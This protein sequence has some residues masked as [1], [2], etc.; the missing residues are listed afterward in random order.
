MRSSKWRSDVCSSDLWTKDRFYVH[1][2]VVKTQSKGGPAF[3]FFAQAK[4]RNGTDNGNYLSAWNFTNQGL[5][6][7]FSPDVL[8]NMLNGTAQIDLGSTGSGFSNSTLSQ[9]YAQVDVT[10]HFDTFIDSV[11][12]G[13]QWRDAEIQRENGRFEW[14]SAAANPHARKSD[15]RGKSVTVRGE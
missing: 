15:G 10:R 3:Q 8:Q 14:Y 7:A 12:V 4:P 6:M 11:P 13:A 5:A 1:F 2:A 9:R